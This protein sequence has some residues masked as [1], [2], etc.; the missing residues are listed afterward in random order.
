MNLAPLLKRTPDSLQTDAISMFYAIMRY[1]GDY[2]SRR[3]D[4]T[5]ELTDQIFRSAVQKQG[6]RDELY[7][8]ILKQLT[9]NYKMSEQKMWQLLWL[10]C[11]L[12]PPS[13]QLYPHVTKFLS[14]RSDL[15][16][17]MECAARVYKSNRVTGTRRFPPHAVEVNIN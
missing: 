3:V 13:A 4:Y 15:P 8:Q 9:R 12:F 6:L 16:M 1:A 5:T 14:S 7:C 17:A 11:G 2:P 10:C